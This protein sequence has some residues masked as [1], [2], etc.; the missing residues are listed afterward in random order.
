MPSCT[1][2][3]IINVKGRNIPK[4][5]RNDA[6][7]TREYGSSPSGKINSIKLHGFGLGGKRDFTVIFA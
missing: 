2:D 7:T 3:K 5:N 6:K 1:A 4:K